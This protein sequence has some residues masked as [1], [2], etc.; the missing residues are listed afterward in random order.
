MADSSV[1]EDV[2]LEGDSVS[3]EPADSAQRTS[4]TA[5]IPAMPT[6]SE[7]SHAV[8]RNAVEMPP[9]IRPTHVWNELIEFV[10]TIAKIPNPGQTYVAGLSTF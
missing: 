1:V 8:Q 10:R 6:E 5:P 9:G 3:R 2:G 4:G 7:S